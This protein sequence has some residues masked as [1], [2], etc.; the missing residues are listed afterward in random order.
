MSR[1]STEL[2][3]GNRAPFAG[4]RNAIFHQV[5][6]WQWVRQIFGDVASGDGMGG[7]AG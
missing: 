5:L 2:V 4:K 1:T 7:S 3:E 6:H